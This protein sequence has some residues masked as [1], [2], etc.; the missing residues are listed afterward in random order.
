MLEPVDV[1]PWLMR[2]SDDKRAPI[3]WIIIGGESGGGAR[4]MHPDWVRDLRDQV[5]VAGAKL[6][7]KQ[8]GTNHALRPGVISKGRRPGPM[9]SRFA[10][11][12]FS[13]MKSFLHLVRR[14]LQSILTTTACCRRAN[15]YSLYSSISSRAGT[16]ARAFSKVNAPAAW[17]RVKAKQWSPYFDRTSLAMGRVSIGRRN[18]LRQCLRPLLMAAIACQMSVDTVIGEARAQVVQPAEA[19]PRARDIGV[20]PGLLRPGALNAITDVDGCVSD[21]SRSL[22]DRPSA[23]ESL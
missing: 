2:T 9:A 15:R 19:R 4:P 10:G 12:G 22:R 13:A 3:S 17:Q 7:V 21:T 8:I 11:A 16:P 14:L 18:M 20:A 23:L 6:F 5:L 1:A